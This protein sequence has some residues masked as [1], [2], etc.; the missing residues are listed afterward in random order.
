MLIRP[1]KKDDI[2]KIEE[3]YRKSP[4][5]YDLP[6]LDSK[7]LLSCLVV[8]DEDDNPRALLAAEK[9][10]ELFLVMDHDF[11]QPSTRLLI[12]E[13][14]AKEITVRLNAQG[15]YT[16]YAFLGPDIPSS[17]HRRLFKLGARKMIW[18]CVKWITRGSGQ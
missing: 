7:N 15:I 16:A 4:A 13:L 9:V 14:L 8:V 2:P 5:K 18:D 6:M 12:I 10:V 11:E 3:I 17:Y 1:M